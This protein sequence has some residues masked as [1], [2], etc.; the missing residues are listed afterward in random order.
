MTIFP[1][2]WTATA[3]ELTGHFEDDGAP[4]S[5]VS[6]NFDGMGVS[7][8]VLQWNFGQGS[9]QPMVVAAGQ[10]AVDAAMPTIGA[11]FWAAANAGPAGWRPIVANWHVGT[12]LKPTAFHELRAFTG[13]VAF[14]AQQI[15]ASEQTA[16]TAFAFAQDWATADATFGTVSKALFCWFF[17]LTTQNGSLKGIGIAQLAAFRASVPDPRGFVCDRL[18]EQPLAVTGA[19]DAHRNAELWRTPGAAGGEHLL[20]LSYLRSLKSTPRFQ[21]DVLNR[22]GTVAQG[23]GWVHGTRHDLTA[24]LHD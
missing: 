22:K 10:A 17:D 24:L 12:T 15:A 13:S 16:R 1:K 11:S 21:I 14:V 9:L 8:G 6:G 7:L 2:A 18:A 5:A 23:I 19:K 4:W 20:L 3:L